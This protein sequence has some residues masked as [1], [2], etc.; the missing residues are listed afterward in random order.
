MARRMVIVGKMGRERM[1]ESST[2]SVN[3]VMEMVMLIVAEVGVLWMVRER[4]N[5]YI[6]LLQ[7]LAIPRPQSSRMVLPTPLVE[8]HDFLWFLHLRAERA[9]HLSQKKF[10]GS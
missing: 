4:W 5:R 1:R 8:T 6:F 3:L 2:G 9:A 10:N 7:V